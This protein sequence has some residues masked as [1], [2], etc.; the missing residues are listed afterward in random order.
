MK[1]KFKNCGNCFFFHKE[2]LY[3]FGSFT[4]R[5]FCLKSNRIIKDFSDEPW[6]YNQQYFL[7]NSNVPNWCKISFL[8]LLIEKKYKNLDK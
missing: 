2:E 4:I 6:L 5:A 8:K 3:I 7:E 1:N